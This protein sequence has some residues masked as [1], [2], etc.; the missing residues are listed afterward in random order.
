MPEDEK[1]I[2]AQNEKLTKENQSQK[3]TITSLE[4]D[5]KASASEKTKAEDA[6]KQKEGENANLK[7]E[8]EKL[9]TGLTE[10]KTAFADLQKQ[11]GELKSSVEGIEASVEKATA[12]R[13]ASMGIKSGIDLTPLGKSTEK[14]DDK[15][16]LTDRCLEAKATV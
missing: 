2:L 13:L 5:L 10:L 12:K 11:F 16:S 9:S 14:S 6:L 3:E 1:D 7:A 15:K 4:N 8:N